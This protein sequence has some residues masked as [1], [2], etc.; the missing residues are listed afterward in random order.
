[1]ED[2]DYF[3]GS[4]AE[5]GNEADGGAVRAG[6]KR[7]GV[8]GRRPAGLLGGPAGS[9][10][11]SGLRGFSSRPAQL[12]GPPGAVGPGFWGLKRKKTRARCCWGCACSVK[13]GIFFSGSW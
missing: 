2:A 1:M 7:L 9:C 6:L 10:P 3:E 13:L 12:G 11:P 4:G 8:G 5:W